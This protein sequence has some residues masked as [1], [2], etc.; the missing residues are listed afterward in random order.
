MPPPWL[1]D[2]SDRDS[3]FD[4][5]II[6]ISFTIIVRNRVTFTSRTVSVW[7]HALTRNRSIVSI[8]GIRS[9][10]K[11]A[12][13]TRTIDFVD[14]D[15][16]R[17]TFPPSVS[18]SARE[19][20]RRAC[21]SRSQS[22]RG[23]GIARVLEKVARATRKVNCRDPAAFMPIVSDRRRAKTTNRSWL[24]VLSARVR[25]R[26]SR[27][28]TSDYFDE[29]FL[30]TEPVRR[31]KSLSF[32]RR[33]HFWMYS[34]LRKSRNVTLPKMCHWLLIVQFSNHEQWNYERNLCLV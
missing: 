24:L 3:S 22:T 30:P 32:K 8:R 6:S 18:K 25:I 5:S 26:F 14:S 17:G 33:S 27:Y 7:F 34:H 1:F 28:R 9:D 20:G 2:S 10:L 31:F 11:R 13:V 16:R 4:S 12:K 21:E 19:M 15:D 29:R 23:I